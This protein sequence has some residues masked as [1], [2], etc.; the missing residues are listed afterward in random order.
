MRIF[1]A[2]NHID[3]KCYGPENRIIIRFR[4]ELYTL[5]IPIYA[6]IIQDST[7]NGLREYVLEF[8]SD[9]RFVLIS[10]SVMKPVNAISCYT[11]RLELAAKTFHAKDG[12]IMQMYDGTK[13]RAIDF[14]NNPRR[15]EYFNLLEVIAV[16]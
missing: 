3:E 6:Q 4:T 12:E 15:A 16:V 13:Q 5:E 11:I 14:M 7:T 2:E 9:I 8:S 10:T 1:D